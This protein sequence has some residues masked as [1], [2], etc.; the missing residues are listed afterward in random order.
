MKII[1]KTPLQDAKGQISLPARVQGTLKY[2]LN[3]YAELEAQKAAI[4]QLD[5]ILEKGAVL[6]RNFTLPN[7]EIVIPLI[8]ISTGGIS[9][10]YVTPVKGF[11]EAKGDQWN[12]V[13]NGRGLPAS[14]NLIDRVSKL[15]R[16]F[17]KYLEMHRVNMSVP[18][19]AVLIATDPGAHIDS[20]RPVARVVMSDA[21]KQF[22][23][24]ILQARPIWRN[25]YVYELADR[26]VDP[27][28][29][30]EAKPEA[31]APAADGRPVSRAKAIFDAAENA[32][33][34]NANELGFAF[35]DG[36][37]PPS[38]Q[39]VPPTV[40]ETNPSRQ[41]PK[42]KPDANKGKILGL[43]NR[44]LILLIGM[45]IVECCVVIGAGVFIY[46]TQ[47]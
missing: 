25:E 2:G 11:F 33:P 40:R 39:P 7:S 8:L 6:I 18:V 34:F 27:R 22:G 20:V 35:E 1:D 47:F 9:V 37:V 17:Q 46:L 44:Q 31:P 10:I 4:A 15:T 38:S 14:I 24:S 16:A 23:N 19:E 26:L 32:Q 42:S 36:E 3:W 30:S 5:R 28:P 13:A 21:I 12:I 43:N 41:L 45:F 29:I